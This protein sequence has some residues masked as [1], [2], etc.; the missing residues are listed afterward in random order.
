[1]VAHAYADQLAELGHDVTVF[2]PKSK[3]QYTTDRKYKIKTLFPIFK[4]GHGAVLPQLMWRLWKFDI[5]HLHYPFFGA[6]HFAIFPKLLS[7]KKKLVVSYHMDTRASGLK[8]YIFKYYKNFFAP[9]VT[10]LADRVIVSSEDYIENSDIQDQYFKM[11]KK[12]VEL[13]FGVPRFFK[14]ELKNVDLMKKYGFRNDDFVVMF[15]GGLDS[16]HYFKGVNYLVKAFSQIE[17]KKIKCLVVGGGSLVKGLKKLRN[18]LGLQNRV[19]FAG[20]VEDLPIYY[21]LCDLFILPSINSSE[22]F[23]I[24]LIEAMSCAKPVVASNLKGVRTVVDQGI[25]GLLIEP[26]N[27]ADIVDK[28]TFFANN[29][30]QAKDFGKR[31]LNSVEKKYRWSIIV[32]KL[33][34][35]YEK[36]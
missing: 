35:I 7:R 6:S 19:K 10:R 2:V 24:V 34:E 36:I 27:S 25:N 32:K 22:A 1:M 26:K 9:I 31:G 15:A 28:I 11:I 33:E 21:N 18:K 20:F 14:P 29:P 8:G 5:V 13:P 4:F 30:T 16:A 17:N 3:N 23:G 12:F